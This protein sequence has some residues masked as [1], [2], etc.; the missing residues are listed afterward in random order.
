MQ[1][2]PVFA[3]VDHALKRRVVD[4][5]RYFIRKLEVVGGRRFGFDAVLLHDILDMWFVG[6]P[7]VDFLDG[8]DFGTHVIFHKLRFDHGRSRLILIFQFFVLI[9]ISKEKLGLFWM[10]IK[11]SK[12]KEKSRFLVRLHRR[13]V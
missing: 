11:G 4:S 3:E 7:S 6:A 1:S 5:V 12:I 9:L 10:K 2:L 8:I 13:I